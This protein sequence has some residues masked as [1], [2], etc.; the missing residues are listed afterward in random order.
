MR[1]VDGSWEYAMCVDSANPV[2]AAGCGDPS[3]SLAPS[4]TKPPAL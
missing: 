4:G 3:S 1:P 2:P